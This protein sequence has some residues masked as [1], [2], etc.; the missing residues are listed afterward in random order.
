[1]AG[2]VAGTMAGITDD[3][4]VITG[5]TAAGIMDGTI[6]VTIGG[7]TGDSVVIRVAPGPAAARRYGNSPARL[8]LAG[9]FLPLTVAAPAGW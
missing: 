1:M 6:V 4:G 5:G 2:T 7:I 8:R 3:T 9:L